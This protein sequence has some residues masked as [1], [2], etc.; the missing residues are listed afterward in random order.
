MTVGTLFFW[1]CAVQANAVAYSKHANV[2]L[3]ELHLGCTHPD[4]E[5]D[6]LCTNGEVCHEDDLEMVFG[7]CSSPTSQQTQ[8]S[9]EVI[10]R[11]VS[12]AANGNPNIGGHSTWSNVASSTKLNALLIGATDAVNQTLYS[13]SCGPVFG[14]TVP[15]NYQL[16]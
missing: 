6:P 10:S 3:Y 12:F 7:T 4:N 15:F 1:T 16:Y 13:N 5:N 8:V 9:N 14:G 2:Y 11:W